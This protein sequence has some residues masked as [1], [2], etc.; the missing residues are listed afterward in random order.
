MKHCSTCRCEKDEMFAAIGKW[1]D[2]EMWNHRN[3]NRRIPDF[4][5]LEVFMRAFREGK[6]LKDSQDAAVLHTNT[7]EKHDDG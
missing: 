5:D 1:L 2:D 6:K 3:S 7:E 4:Q